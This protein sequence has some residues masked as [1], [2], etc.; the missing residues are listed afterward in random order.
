MRRGRKTSITNK[1]LQD[2]ETALKIMKAHRTGGE[3]TKYC[4]C[5]MILA[6]RRACASLSKD[7]SNPRKV[8]LHAQTL[9]K[10]GQKIA[11]LTSWISENTTVK[12]I[13]NYRCIDPIRYIPAWL[14][15]HFKKMSVTERKDLNI[16]LTTHAKY[17]EFKPD[18][19]KRVPKTLRGILAQQAREKKRNGV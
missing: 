11:V 1:N 19:K 4:H 15:Q 6:H 13:N 10:I 8:A 14:R 5:G 12:T 16:E 3:K 9:E 7:P 17:E 2:L 18:R